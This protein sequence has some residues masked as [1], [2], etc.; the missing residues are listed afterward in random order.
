MAPA[1]RRVGH[2]VVEPGHACGQHHEL[3]GIKD[4]SQA[5]GQ[6]IDQALGRR[7]HIGRQHQAKAQQQRPQRD[8]SP[9][10]QH[11]LAQRPQ[12]AHAPDVVERAVDGQDQRKGR[13]HQDGEADQAQLTGLGGELRE[14]AQHL[15]RN[16]L[17]NQAVHQPALQ[18]LLRLAKDR[19]GREQGQRHGKKRHQRQQRCESKTAGGHAQTVFLEARQQHLGRVVPG[20]GTQA[21]LRTA[22]PAAQGRLEFLLAGHLGLGDTPGQIL[23]AS[24]Q[25]PG[26]VES[27]AAQALGNALRAVARTVCCA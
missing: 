5:A 12:L 22:A 15:A 4:K 3:Y 17:G 25:R 2:I 14:I 10:N 8:G 23:A 27:A 20:E 1:H 21:L 9:V 11:P 19:E 7:H 26:L 24:R 6:C 18:H 16:G 13:D